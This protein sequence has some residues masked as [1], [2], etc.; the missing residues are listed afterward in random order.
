M[1][2]WIQSLDEGALRFI[3]E[4]L[5]APWLDGAVVFYTKL[6]NLGAVFFAAAIILLC[7]RK[8][9][10]YGITAL[11]GLGIGVLEVNVIIKPLVN[12]PRPYAVM[13]DFT[14]LLH[15]SDGFSFPSGHTNAA[16]AFAVALCFAL[17]K[18]YRAWKWT[19]VAAAALMGLSRLYVGV[20]Y[21]TDVLAGVVTGSLAGA[22]GHWLV[23]KLRNHPQGPR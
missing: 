17:P 14:S 21:P 19:A 20:H 18:K 10:R 2:G 7:I 16:F 5:R 13:E 12:R 15:S 3:A 22:A 4:H 23:E 6:G 8:T 1:L 9:R 11:A